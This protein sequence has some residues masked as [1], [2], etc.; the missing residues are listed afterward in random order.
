MYNV[1]DGLYLSSAEGGSTAIGKVNT[2]ALT[3]PTGN[4]NPIRVEF[5]D[6]FVILARIRVEPQ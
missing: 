6:F 5:Y 2:A 3:N 1:P 4:P